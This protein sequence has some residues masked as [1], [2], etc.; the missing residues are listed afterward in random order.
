MSKSSKLQEV[1]EDDKGNPSNNE[2][3]PSGPAERIRGGFDRNFDNNSN[4][5]DRDDGGY[6]S[7]DGDNS[8][9]D[10]SNDD[11]GPTLRKLA[12]EVL[13][14]RNDFD[15]TMQHFSGPGC[16]RVLVKWTFPF[17]IPQG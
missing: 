17:K 3:H 10:Y 5:N 8:G 16:R 7:G 14:L 9:V 13:A 15:A 12:D 4:S 6:N 11:M 1:R 2:T